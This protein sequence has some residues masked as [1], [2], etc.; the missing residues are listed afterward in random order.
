M[1][2]TDE[3]LKERV[4]LHKK[5]RLGDPTGVRLVLPYGAD[6][7]GANLSEA[8]LEDIKQDFLEILSLAPTEV[9]ALK[10]AIIEGR[11]NGSVYQGECACLVGTIANVR[12]VDVYTELPEGL[13]PNSDR[14]AERWFLGIRKGDTPATNQI[15]KITLA[16]LEEWEAAQSAQPVE[17]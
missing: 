1:Q 3:E 2:F 13:R 5:W 12:G 10:A 14:P 17:G 15:S 7:S 8:Y 16:W 4:Q 11:I 6:L 9:P